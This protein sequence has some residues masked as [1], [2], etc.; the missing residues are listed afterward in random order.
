MTS[1]NLCQLLFTQTW[2][3]TLLAMSVWCL[4]RLCL[5]GRPW[6]AHL[7]WACV[8]IKVIVPPIMASPVGLFAWSYAQPAAAESM[9]AERSGEVALFDVQVVETLAATPSPASSSIAPSAAMPSTSSV[10]VA[11]WLSVAGGLLLLSVYRCGYFMWRLPSAT[12]PSTKFESLLEKVCLRLSPATDRAAARCGCRA[13]AIG[14][15][16]LAT[17]SGVAKKDCRSVERCADRSLAH[18]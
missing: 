18:A 17:D 16:F 2:Q 1:D 15:W 3:V 13:R 10:I 11:V 5:R 6:M 12:F 8:L 9:V 14:V 4:T 7:L